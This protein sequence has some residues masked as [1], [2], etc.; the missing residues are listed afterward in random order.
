MVVGAD[1]NIATGVSEYSICE[2]ND[3]PSFQNDINRYILDNE[4]TNSRKETKILNGL[5][6]NWI[7]ETLNDLRSRD[8]GMRFLGNISLTI[9]GSGQLITTLNSIGTNILN[10]ING[11]IA[12]KQMTGLYDVK[13]YQ[14]SGT[15]H[16]ILLTKTK[17]FVTWS[18]IDPK[19][20]TV[21]ISEDNR[22]ICKIE[23]NVDLSVNYPIVLS[24]FE[25][26][27][28]TFS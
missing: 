2:I 22:I 19:V 7:I 21:G 14:D 11:A 8:S 12:T 16:Q 27:S 25:I 20:V 24:I 28:P 17:Y 6:F 18:L 3:T 4:F 1:N 13:V 15:T 26:T 23:G 10:G 5:Q 9:N